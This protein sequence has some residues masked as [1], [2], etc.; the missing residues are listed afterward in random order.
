MTQS[1]AGTFTLTDDATGKSYKLPVIDGTMG[2]SVIDVRKLYAET[3]HFTYDPGFTSTGSCESALTYIDGDEGILLHRGYSIEDLAENSDFL[4]VAYLLL[5]GDLPN[6]DQKKKFDRDVTY[7]TMVHEQLSN[8]YRGFRRDAHP[9]AVLCGVIGALSAFYHDSTDI[10]DE[11]QRMVASFRLVAKMPTIAAMAYKYSVGQPFNYPRNDLSYAENFL[12]MMFAVP[13][14]PYKISPT[15]ARAM[16][17]ILI[18]HADH[19]QNA[20]TSTV[21]L[22]GSSGANPFACI[23]AG[24]A[25]LWGPAH[26]GANEA[27]L[28]MLQEIGHKDNIN[29]FIKRAKDKDDPFRLMGFGHRVYKNYDPRAKVMQKSCHEVLAEL[30][31]DDPL[32]ELAM[33]L[34]KIALEDEYF[35]DRKLFPNVDFYSGIV[36][37]ALGF[38][39]SMFT[40]LF[41]V[42]RTV[43]WVAQWKEM[44][45]EPGQKIG[46]PRQLY[47]GPE[48]RA[49]VPVGQR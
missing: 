23:A 35:V 7:H 44:I 4:D 42:A 16:D 30:D 32:L 39:T 1:N 48:K 18:L 11:H 17:R 31:L 40:V 6:R 45:E 49:Y 12:H 8:F 46:R 24:I 33:A 43:G 28:N 27:V 36:L 25:S 26:G 47:T 19:E 29:E 5:Y 15:V 3:G 9:M 2:P 37:K 41:A 22:S 38:P 21:R 20:S 13:A 14:E 10:H 34:E